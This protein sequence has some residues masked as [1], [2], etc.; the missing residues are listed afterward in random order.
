MN[1]SADFLLNGPVKGKKETKK[2]VPTAWKDRISH[3]DYESLRDTFLIFDEDGSGKIDPIE[4]NK[5]FEELDLH[6]RS[7]F[8]EHIITAIR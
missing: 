3:E 4:I 5:V 2:P 6:R 7:P 1:R 8:I